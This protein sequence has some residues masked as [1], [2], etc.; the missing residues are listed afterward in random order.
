MNKNKKYKVDDNYFE[1]IDNEEK[2]YWLGFLYADGNVRI[3]KNSGIL[4]LKLKQ[5]DKHHVENF[6]KCINSNYL[7]KDGLEILKHKN[8][9]YKCYYSALCIYN[10]KLVKDLYNIGCVN[11]KTQKI[12]LPNIND[13][14]IQHFIRGYFDGDGCIHKLKSG[15]NCYDISIVSNTNFIVDLKTHFDNIFN[16]DITFYENKNKMYSIL[17]ISA[18]EIREKFYHYI[19]DNSTIY[20]ERKKKIFEDMMIIKDTNRK[21]KTNIKKHKV[22]NPNNDIVFTDKGLASFCRDNNLNYSSIN[23]IL[24]GIIDNYKGWKIELI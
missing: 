16:S 23:N 18:R 20:L 17:N 6:N 24:R 1:N 22:T 5:S 19:Y 12:R 4:K 7:I 3:R 8:K 15:I 2:A 14:F 9:E 13:I 10:T 11:N 21:G